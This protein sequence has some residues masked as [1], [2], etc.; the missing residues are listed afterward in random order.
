MEIENG[1]WSRFPEA[2]IQKVRAT[3]TENR[4]KITIILWI[5]HLTYSST[6]YGGVRI[7]PFVMIIRIP[8]FLV[9][10]VVSTNVIF[11]QIGHEKDLAK[12]NLVHLTNLCSVQFSS[13][14]YSDSEDPSIQRKM[15]MLMWT[16]INTTIINNSY[17]TVGHGKVDIQTFERYIT[18]KYQD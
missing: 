9:S 8:D 14:V 7:D 10:L 17:N 4:W 13:I 12:K 1:P 6:R 18:M 15:N 2:S 5:V 3:Q 16:N 11:E